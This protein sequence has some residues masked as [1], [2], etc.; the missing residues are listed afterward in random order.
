MSDRVHLPPVHQSIWCTCYLGST[1]QFWV[2]LIQYESVI[3]I[4]LTTVIKMTTSDSSPNG[5]R[6][7]L[8][9]ADLWQKFY[10]VNEMVASKPGRKLFPELEVNIEGLDP[11][12]LYEVFLYLERV[13]DYKYKFIKD[14]ESGI[15]KWEVIG[16]VLKNNIPIDKR[17]HKNG[18]RSGFDWMDHPV[19]FSSICITN[20]PN[21]DEQKHNKKAILVSPMHKYQ[22][23]ISVKRLSDGKEEEFRLTM[24]EFMVMTMYQNPKIIELKI[25]NNKFAS[26]FR[27]EKR[28]AT[29]TPPVGSP[30]SPVTKKTAPVKISQNQMATPPKMPVTPSVA[31]T[32]VPS[33]VMPMTTPLFQGTMSHQNKVATPTVMTPPHTGPSYIQNQMMAPSIVAPPA[34]TMTTSP[35]QWPTNFQN[36]MTTPP[37]M[38]PTM[39]TPPSMF[40]T[41]MAPSTMTPPSMGSYNFQNPM[42]NPLTMTPQNMAPLSITIPPDHNYT[43]NQNWNPYQTWNMPQMAGGAPMAPQWNMMNAQFGHPG[44]MPQNNGTDMSFLH[45]STAADFDF[46]F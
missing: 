39:T 35:S 37:A 4:W 23:V 29:M 5:V 13:D 27:G 7:S 32:F 2:G 9:N 25:E 10:P 1:P 15:S 19:S 28:S 16:H 12:A 14:K 33:P 21:F 18:A 6:V 26:K 20:D 41:P 46:R 30:A 31:I 38:T 24:T 40:P 11:Y 22:P 34:V 45:G 8:H 44:S 42:I 43:M 3:R 36:Q 17:P